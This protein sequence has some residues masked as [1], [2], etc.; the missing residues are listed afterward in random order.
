MIKHMYELCSM[1]RECP[2]GSPSEKFD[3][4]KKRTL[5]CVFGGF[6]FLRITYPATFGSMI[7]VLKL[8]SL[9]HMAAAHGRPIYELTED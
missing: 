3:L 2:S 4:P 6:G 9:L 5:G 7:E 1:L 8:L